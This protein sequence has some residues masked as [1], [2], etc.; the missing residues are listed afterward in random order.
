M[1]AIEQL[2]T[3]ESS[4]GSWLKVTGPGRD[5]YAAAQMV[6]LLL[7]VQND[8]AKTG[9]RLLRLG[10]AAC[11]DPDVS[12]VLPGQDAFLFNKCHAEMNVQRVVS[13]TQRRLMD[14]AAVIAGLPPNRCPLP[15]IRR[16]RSMGNGGFRTVERRVDGGH[17]TPG[18]AAEAYK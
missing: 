14:P 6:H 13:L 2:K 12:D 5:R 15:L 8:L 3:D 4:P 18:I 17:L 10:G 16:T 11:P 9:V 7:K 1:N